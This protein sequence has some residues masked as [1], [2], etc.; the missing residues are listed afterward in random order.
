MADREVVPPPHIEFISIL[1]SANQ[2]PP[3]P[4]IPP[5]T[6]INSSICSPD[7]DSNQESTTKLTTKQDE[8]DDDDTTRSANSCGAYIIEIYPSICFYFF[9]M[10]VSSLFG[11]NNDQ[12]KYI[13]NG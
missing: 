1:N 13:K 5:S 3:Y 4:V 7:R 10:C 11:K 12:E 2:Y 6:T 8:D 9:F